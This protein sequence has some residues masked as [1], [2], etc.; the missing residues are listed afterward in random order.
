MG[1][2]WRCSDDVVAHNLTPAAPHIIDVH[3]LKVNEA[4]KRTE[5][6]LRDAYEQGASELRVITGKG[7]H[8]QGGI[9]VLK[10]AI[11]TT[12]QK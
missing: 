6:A 1:A 10:S 9:P 2:C 4:V 3:R 7:N 5:I 12:L 11:M 8:S